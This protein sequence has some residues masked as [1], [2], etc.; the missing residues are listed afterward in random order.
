M[1][2][3]AERAFRARHFI[4]PVKITVAGRVQ[5]VDADVKRHPIAVSIEE[6]EAVREVVRALNEY[7]YSDSV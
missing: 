1:S 4:M 5:N 3:A 6:K 7:Y 2:T